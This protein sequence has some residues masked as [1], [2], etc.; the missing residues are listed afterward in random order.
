[1]YPSVFVDA[2]V[3]SHKGC[4]QVLEHGLY[5]DYALNSPWALCVVGLIASGD[6]VAPGAHCCIWDTGACWVVGVV[7]AVY[8]AFVDVYVGVTVGVVDMLAAVFGVA[9]DGVVLGDVFV[10]VV[11]VVVWGDSVSIVAA[12]SRVLVI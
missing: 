8:G 7:D 10:V 2:C 4:L 1:M 6:H 11:V 12:Y 5:D 3:E 9:G